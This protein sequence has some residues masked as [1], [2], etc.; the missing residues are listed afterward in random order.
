M[1]SQR[2]LRSA[3]WACLIWVTIALALIACDSEDGE[4]ATETDIVMPGIDPFCETR[5]KIE[6][7][8]D[9]DTRDLPGAFD[10]QRVDAST[11]TLD[12]DEASSAPRSLLIT[13][14]PGGHA[15]LR[16]S[17]EPGGK[18]R[19]FGMLYVPELG[20]GDVKIAAFELGDYRIGFGVSEDGSLWGYEG[21]QRIDGS[22]SIPVGRWASFRWDVNV[23][24][25]GTGTAKLR[26]G[27]D[28][29]VDA[30]LT[31]PVGFNDSPITSIGLFEATGDWTIQLDTITV[32]VT[33]ASP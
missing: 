29:F 7:C 28:T 6:F 11:M 8:E 30:E 14:E 10:E 16:H 15:Q 25:D 23:Y 9:F 21:D 24:D 33:E 22:G 1:E 2:R 27:F 31:A 13:A 4:T 12:S 18:L 20:E 17:F 3:N 26:F 5:P 32:A 19:L